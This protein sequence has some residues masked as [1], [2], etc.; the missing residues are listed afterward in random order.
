MDVKQRIE[1]DV[2][3]GRAVELVDPTVFTM[4]PFEDEEFWSERSV[5]GEWLADFLASPGSAHSR[6][7]IILRGLRVCG[8]VPLAGANI[9]N[10]IEL[11]HCQFGGGSFAAEEADL[12]SLNLTSTWCESVNLNGARIVGSV[13]LDRCDVSAG[14]QLVGAKITGNFKC[15]HA[16]L[17]A[18]GASAGGVF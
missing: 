7:T 16:V 5:D 10:R 8:D 12:R 2:A 17:R 13:L 14:V 4:R 1:V 11:T 9:T 6:G 18:S 15:R 3:D